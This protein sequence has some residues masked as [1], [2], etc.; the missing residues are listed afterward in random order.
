[1]KDGTIQ[2]AKIIY[3]SLDEE[4][5]FSEYM[6]KYKKLEELDFVPKSFGFIFSSVP[7]IVGEHQYNVGVLINQ[8]I[9]HRQIT[10]DNHSWIMSLVDKLHNHGWIHGDITEPKNIVIDT[11]NKRALFIDVDTTF[12]VTSISNI[13]FKEEYGTD[14]IKTIMEFERRAC[15][16]FASRI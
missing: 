10:L 4:Y 7:V 2:C 13:N 1:M 15:E 11:V 6:L 3:Y 5:T 9:E 8:Y 14:N 12:H 16:L